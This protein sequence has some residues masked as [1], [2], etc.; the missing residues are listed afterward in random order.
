MGGKK[1]DKK[2][3]AEKAAEAAAKAQKYMVS[4]GRLGR[5]CV[6]SRALAGSVLCEARA[7]VETSRPPPA[8]M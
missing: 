4:L 7:K 2:D 8:C 6:G 5:G 3:P 1:P